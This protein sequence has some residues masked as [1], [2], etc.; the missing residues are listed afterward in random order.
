MKRAQSV[1]VLSVLT[2]SPRKTKESAVPDEF[3]RPE[4]RPPSESPPPLPPREKPEQSNVNLVLSTAPAL[5]N[6][7]VIIAEKPGPPGSSVLTIHP[8]PT[9]S[10]SRSKPTPKPPASTGVLFGVKSRELPAPDTV[11]ETRKLFEADGSR[12]SYRKTSGLT[13]SKSTS[14]LYTKPLSR[15]NSEEKI[16]LSRKKSE[17]DLLKS[18]AAP[19]QR[20]P[21]TRP[22]GY[23]RQSSAGAR[24]STASP[25]RS[26]APPT[27][28]PDPQFA[29][30]SSPRVIRPVI[31][32]KPSHLSPI[33]INT[34]RGNSFD[35][36]GGKGLHRFSGT[37]GYKQESPLIQKEDKSSKIDIDSVRLNLTPISKKIHP[38]PTEP[39]SPVEPSSPTELEE[40]FKKISLDTIQNIR[41]DG[42]VLNFSFP[43]SPKSTKSYLPGAKPSESK[44]TAQKP[45]LNGSNFTGVNSVG[46]NPGQTSP[47]AGSEQ[48]LFSNTKQEYITSTVKVRF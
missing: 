41:R 13:K 10:Y 36:P 40:G 30:K 34:Y 45:T 23:M 35:S 29:K 33:V 21:S 4:S 18:V 22:V 46:A 26:I 11:K 47:S 27:L 1:E 14:S 48:K 20:R 12:S 8:K 28:A 43:D 24:T 38:E 3:F 42:N 17:E 39:S 6:D 15:S 32:A 16:N 19:S 25:A 9:P 2:D 44:S 31:P 37:T 5:V 7:S